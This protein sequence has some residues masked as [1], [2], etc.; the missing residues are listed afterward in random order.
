MNTDLDVYANPDDTLTFDGQDVNADMPD[1][2]TLA[3]LKGELGLDFQAI[4]RA[5]EDDVMQFLSDMHE[6]RAS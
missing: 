3:A 4:D 5:A 1:A 6:K 2:L